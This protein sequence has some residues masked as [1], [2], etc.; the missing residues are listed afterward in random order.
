MIHRVLFVIVMAA[1]AI[2]A[3]RPAVNSDPLAPL[4]FLVRSWR[5]EQS[6]EPRQGHF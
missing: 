4:K 5:G 2:V 1:C 6:G 3:Q